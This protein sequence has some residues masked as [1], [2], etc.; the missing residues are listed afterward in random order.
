MHLSEPSATIVFVVDDAATAISLGS[1]DVPVLG[2]PKVVALCEEAAVAAIAHLVPD[3]ATT[4]GSEIS[5][6]HSAPSPLG[7]TV[8]ATARMIKEDGRTRK[9]EIQVTQEGSIVASGQ[10][11]R[12]T[13]DRARFLG[14]R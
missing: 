6:T 1:G 8:E 11:T 13:V 7:S 9:F 10:H 12:I 14:S 5:L 3:G 4:V 2:T